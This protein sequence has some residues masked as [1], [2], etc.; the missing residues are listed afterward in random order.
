MATY[1]VTVDWG[2]RS[3]ALRAMHTNLKPAK[4]FLLTTAGA[5][6]TVGA[7]TTAQ[8]AGWDTAVPTPLAVTPVP[9]TYTATAA[10]PD[11]TAFVRLHFALRL[12]IGSA[13]A[14]C[15]EFRQLLQLGTGGALMPSQHSFENVVY[16][17][18]AAGP[19]RLTDGGPT[20]RILVD[21]SPLV[22][23]TATS[24]RPRYYGSGY[25]RTSRRLVAHENHTS[26]G[27]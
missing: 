24:V 13:T 27:S 2:A 15:L 8:V 16:Q 18:S 22:S 4:S 26:V 19:V 23:L 5:P 25:P 17:P 7:L 6:V 10:V 21:A 9:R 1:T 20:R 3:E 14:T 11:S 12:T